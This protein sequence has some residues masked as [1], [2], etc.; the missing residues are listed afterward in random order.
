[1]TRM[2]MMSNIM[3]PCE[4]DWKTCAEP[5]KLALMVAGRCSSV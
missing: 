3:S 2:A 5:W 4:E 1:M